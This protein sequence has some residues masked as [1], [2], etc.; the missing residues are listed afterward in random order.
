MRGTLCDAIDDRE[1][2]Q[3][4]YDGYAR[5]VEPHK[6][7]RTTAGNDVL[8]GF[9]TAGGSDSGDVP[10]WKL[11]KLSGI[12]H[13]N[14]TGDTFGGPRNGYSRSDDRMDRIYCRL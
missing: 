2:V 14:A 3:F 1:V 8:S 4:R 13:L 6:V 5:T 7:G 11:F 9:Q 12:R 10:N